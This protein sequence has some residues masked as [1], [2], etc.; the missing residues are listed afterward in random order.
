MG[1]AL[2]N[3]HGTLDVTNSTL[4]GN[5]AAGGGGGSLEA[6]GFGGAVFNYN[7]AL[8]ARNATFSHNTVS[9]GTSTGTGGMADGGAIFSV[10]DSASPNGNVAASVTLYNSI[11]ANTI[12]PNTA[13]AADFFHT[14]LGTGTSNANVG[15]N[16]LVE[17]N[18]ASA[19][20]YA[21]GMIAAADPQLGPLADNGGPTFTHAPAAGSPVL[22]AG[23]NAAAAG[24]TADQRGL[25]FAR[26][27]DGPD[28]GAT[29]T[30]DIGA[31]ESR[32]IP[33]FDLV[34]T[35]AADE[36]DDDLTDAADLS[37]REA[38]FI[39]ENRAGADVITF[40]PAL[41]A[42][43][44]ATITL[45]QF[46]TGV[47]T[48]EFGPTALHIG[49]DVTIRGP[50]GANGLTIRR[51]TADT[52]AFRLFY[53]YNPAA[54]ASAALRLENLTLAGGLVAASAGPA[55]R[56][57]WAGPSSTGWARSR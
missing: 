32:I 34:V 13:G 17:T 11:L 54:P 52:N 43:G 23:D 37:L 36:L 30:V 2:F 38:V 12:H 26:V 50:G 55:G 42:G 40:A 46:D 53:V 45:T 25:P 24:L 4:S 51:D 57:A 22:D 16:N 35:T 48:D 6:S 15:S 56:P 47:D 18:G 8:T 3:Y 14:A 19:N 21:G 7:G 5:A 49:S 44:D 41:T 31:V 9:A 29:A 20:G 28:A 33:I 39:A 1:G 10:G 27:V